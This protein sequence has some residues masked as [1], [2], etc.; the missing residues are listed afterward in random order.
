MRVS[1][2][3]TECEKA[4]TEKSFL[5]VVTVPGSFRTKPGRGDPTQS[6]S[7]SDKMTKWNLVG[8]QGSLLSA[9]TSSPIRWSSVTVGSD[10]HSSTSLERT[11]FQRVKKAAGSGS[12]ST[13]VW[14]LLRTFR[15][16][17]FR[18]LKT[19]YIFA[20]FYSWPTFDIFSL[21]FQFS[22]EF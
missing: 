15:T 14:S 13:Q 17:S 7:C 1:R 2:P 4:T 6:L 22:F 10:Q 20:I 16:V 5:V 12:D 3:K 19:V 18:H 21:G 11:L 8:L 9:L